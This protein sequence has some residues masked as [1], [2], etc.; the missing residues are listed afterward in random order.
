MI[1]PRRKKAQYMFGVCCD[2]PNNAT[3]YGDEVAETIF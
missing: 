1:I 3:D 2:F